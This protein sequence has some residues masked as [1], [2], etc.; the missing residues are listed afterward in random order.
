MNNYRFKDLTPLGREFLLDQLKR[1]YKKYKKLMQN[2]TGIT[3][4]PVTFVIFASNSWRKD[5]EALKELMNE[6]INDD[7]TQFPETQENEE[8]TTRGRKQ[9]FESTL[10]DTMNGFREFQRQ[11]LQ[12]FRQNLFYLLEL[13]SDTDFYC[14][15]IHA[16][17]ICCRK[18]FIDLGERSTEDKL[19][20]VQALTRYS[21]DSEFVG[22][23]LI[24][25]QNCGSPCPS[26]FTFSSPYS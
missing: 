11:S 21:H 24:S 25:G 18:Y 9:L 4:D 3:V 10:T 14:A 26:N 15:C 7:E 12:K 1:K 17:K 8:F 6:G 2:S 22:T 20:F 13:S 19:R 16:F 5:R 23:C